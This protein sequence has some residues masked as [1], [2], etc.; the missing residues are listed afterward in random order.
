MSVAEVPKRKAGR[1][2][3]AVS[4]EKNASEDSGGSLRRVSAFQDEDFFRKQNVFIL[5]SDLTKLVITARG[6][7]PS[8]V[9]PIEIYRLAKQIVDLTYDGEP[10]MK[11]E[12]PK[13]TSLRPDQIAMLGADDGWAGDDD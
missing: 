12:P 6:G 2:K 11:I 4:V 3:K 10:K 13:L 7:K 1:P 9:Q 5:A 8:A